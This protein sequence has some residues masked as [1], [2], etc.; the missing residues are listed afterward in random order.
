MDKRII[1]VGGAA[2]LLALLYLRRNPEA[3]E[4]AKAAF[5]KLP[6]LAM[7]PNVPRDPMPNIAPNEYDDTHYGGSTTGGV[8]PACNG[9][10]ESSF[11]IQFGTAVEQAAWFADRGSIYA[12][13]IARAIPDEVLP[14]PVFGYAKPQPSYVGVWNQRASYSGWR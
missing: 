13:N 6:P 8:T 7:P 3:V 5:D 10:A 2:A 14:D 4:A 9:C 11:T 1:V 12:K